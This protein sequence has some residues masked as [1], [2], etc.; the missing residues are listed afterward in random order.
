MV[1]PRYRSHAEAR[2]IPKP[3]I[4]ISKNGI[5][6]KKLKQIRF[7]EEGDKTETSRSGKSHTTNPEKFLQSYVFRK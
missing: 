4:S 3:P 7:K 2:P 6:A 5:S 1:K